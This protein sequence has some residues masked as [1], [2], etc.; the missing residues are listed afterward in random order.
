M[1]LT[2]AKSG[3]NISLERD[4]WQSMGLIFGNQ[5]DEPKKSRLYDVCIYIFPEF[6]FRNS[7]LRIRL[8]TIQP[9]T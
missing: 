4:F 7:K 6:L 8:I 2:L 3:T 5:W 1:G 9:T